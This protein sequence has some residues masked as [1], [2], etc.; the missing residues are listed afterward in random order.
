MIWEETAAT[1]PALKAVAPLGY[2]ARVL[3]VEDDPAL[4][5]MVARQLAP[6]GYQVDFAADGQAGLQ[7]ARQKPWDIVVADRLIQ[8][9]MDARLWRKSCPP[10]VD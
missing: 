10:H 4:R 9:D 7:L 2:K 1:E 6:S 3:L 8:H 5:K